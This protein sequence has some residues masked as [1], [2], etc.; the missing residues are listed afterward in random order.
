MPLTATTK[1][2][3]ND[4]TFA[5][6]KKGVRIINIAKGGVINKDALVKAIDA[7]TV[8]QAVVDIFADRRIP[9]RKIAS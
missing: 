1:K 4:T 2:I 7:G 3:L 6:M 8:A 9:H 5:K